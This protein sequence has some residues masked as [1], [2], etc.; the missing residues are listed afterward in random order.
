MRNG[1]L[2]LT[3]TEAALTAALSA[4]ALLLG[5]SAAL[6]GGDSAAGQKVFASR[7]GGCHATEFGVNKV[8][9]SLAGVFSR[10]SGSITGFNYSPALKAANITWD[11]KTLDQ[12]LVNPVGDV[13]GTKMFANL[14]NSED[15]QNV[16]ANCDCHVAGELT[17]S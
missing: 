14:P 2:I 3:K 9:P 6:A 12:F 10:K 15:R 1:T 13:H 16:I 4:I 17:A 11:E 7:C 5:S 8:G